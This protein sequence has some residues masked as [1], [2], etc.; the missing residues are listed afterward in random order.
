MD[1]STLDL[2][3]HTYE[4]IKLANSNVDSE[5]KCANFEMIKDYVE[6]KR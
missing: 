2:E 6:K 1:N 5:S 3:K 4:A